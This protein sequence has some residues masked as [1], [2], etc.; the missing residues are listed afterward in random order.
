M[1][2]IEPTD[3][4]WA[5]VYFKLRLYETS[6]NE[7]QSL[8]ADL[9]QMH[10]SDFQ[11]VRP[12]GQYGDGGNDGYVPSQQWYLQMYGPQAGSQIPP[13][14][15]ARK[16]QD[17]FGKLRVHYPTMQRYSF[18][19]NDRFCGV[20]ANLTNTLQ[21]MSSTTGVQCDCLDSRKLTT[22]FMGLNREGK[23]CV[24]KSYPGSLPDWID[25]SALGEVLQHLASHD[26]GWGIQ[27]KNVAPD[28]DAKIRFNGL[29]GYAADRL[30][31]MSY[32]VGSVDEFFGS[33]DPYRAQAVAQELRKLY[34]QSLQHVPD[35]AEDA[36]ALRYT[37]MVENMIPPVARQNTFV[38]KSFRE[39]AEVVLA[40]YF[41]TCDVYAK[42][43]T[44]RSA[45]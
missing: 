15:L 8:V 20:P 29:D 12:S 27:S 25:P 30:R 28:F 43:G 16:A 6:G 7:F 22:L 26:A 31:C 41:E 42:P 2:A 23:I 18:V 3:R 38:L 5:H 32:Q 36:A 37:W 11:A 14:K 17:D 9:M 21:E 1:D 45:A 24:L 35:E 4:Y 33:R 39:A 13:R 34:E 19:F 40:K 10:Y 44:G